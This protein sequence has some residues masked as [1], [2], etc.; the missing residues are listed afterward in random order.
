MTK[1]LL[2]GKE[3][4]VKETPNPSEKGL[5][6]TITEDTLNTFVIKTPKGLKRIAKHQRVFIINNKE[7]SGDTLR[8]RVEDRIKKLKK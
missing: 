3:I 2:I 7:Y 5:T 1:S 6:G 4:T 8:T